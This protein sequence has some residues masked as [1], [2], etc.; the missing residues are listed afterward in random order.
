MSTFQRLYFINSG[1][2]IQEIKEEEE[3]GGRKRAKKCV[4]MHF[5]CQKW[6]V[7]FEEILLQ[8]WNKLSLGVLKYFL[9]VSP[10]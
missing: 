6:K 4:T 2:I 5:L 8:L 3:G 7:I 1:T 9:G 10:T